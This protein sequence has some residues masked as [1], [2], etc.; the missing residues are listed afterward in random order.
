MTINAI[1][2]KDTDGYFAFVPEFKG[3]VTCAQSHEEAVANIT[4]AAQ[5]YLES[6]ANDERANIASRHT[7][8]VPIEVSQCLNFRD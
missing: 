2:E 4:E 1:I 5:L 8:I 7:A 6:L 3:C